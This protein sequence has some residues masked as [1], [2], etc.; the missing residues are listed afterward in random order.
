MRNAHIQLAHALWQELL[1]PGDLVVDATCG[2]GKDLLL[3]CQKVLRESTGHVFALDLQQEAIEQSRRYLQ[4]NL[5]IDLLSRV[6]F[7][8]QCHSSF[9]KEIAQE[10]IRLIVYNLGYRP[11][12]NKQIT[13]QTATTLQS[14]SNAMGLV[15]P[16]GRIS[17]TCY[18]GHVEGAREQEA[19]L[20]FL[21]TLP[22][23]WSFTWIVPTQMPL[24]RPALLVLYRQ[25]IFR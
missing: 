10:S 16:G 17:L 23:S 4:E 13:T 7:F 11:T 22:S 12:G 5:A 9:P 15:R 14:I 24:L 2:N 21:Q 18:P 6:T 25:E 19:I 3:L 1:Q 20:D 8:Q